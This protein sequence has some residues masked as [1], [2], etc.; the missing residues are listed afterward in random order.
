MAQSFEASHKGLKYKIFHDNMLS[1][2][3][4]DGYDMMKYEDR[5][6][7]YARVYIEVKVCVL[8]ARMRVHCSL[9]QFIRSIKS[10][11]KKKT[12]CLYHALKYVTQYL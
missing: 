5:L 12:G 11:K 7:I 6:P 4:D 2:H 10:F 1:Y 3:D 8:M 9:K